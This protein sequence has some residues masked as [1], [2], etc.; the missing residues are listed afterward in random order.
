MNLRSRTALVTGG[1]V[2]IGRAIC[3]ALAARGCRV[4]V[5]Y[6][7]SGKPAKA[8]AD[9]LSQT[10]VRAFTVRAHLATQGDCDGLIN[11]AWALAGRVDFLVNNAAVFHKEGLMACDEDTILAELRT[12]LVAPMLLSR[13]FA[14]KAGREAPGLC[15]KIVNLLDR[16]IAGNEVGCLPYLLSKKGLAEFTRNAALELAPR[17]TVNGVA[18][19]AILPPPGKGAAYIRDLAGTVPLQRRCRPEDVAAAVVYLL[20]SDA[21]TGQIV[22]VDG[23]QHLLGS[24]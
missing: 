20:E 12:N 2:R 11:E 17:F 3:A 14:A 5:H 24:A 13:A 21:V 18:P 22:F 1:A 7:R 9:A 16:R 10:G 23:G 8:L 4:I 6:D 19:G 15:G